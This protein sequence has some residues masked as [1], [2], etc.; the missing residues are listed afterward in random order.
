MA[1]L[2]F[3]YLRP[4]P[5]EQRQ[6][7]AR[8]PCLGGKGGDLLEQGGAAHLVQ[9]CGDLVQQQDRRHACAVARKLARIRQQD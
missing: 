9:V 3:E 6:V 1:I 7:G 2:H 4:R 8:H 5:V